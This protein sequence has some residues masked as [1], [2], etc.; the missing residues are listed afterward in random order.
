[1]ARA[2]VTAAKAR[3]LALAQPTQVVA[4]PG[5]GIRGAWWRARSQRPRSPATDSRFDGVG[6]RPDRRLPTRRPTARSA[7]IDALQ[8]ARASSR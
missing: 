8:R 5:A 6:A 3:G 2:I 4:E 7:A 1:M